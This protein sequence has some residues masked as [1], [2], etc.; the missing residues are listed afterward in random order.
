MNHYSIFQTSHYLNDN[1]RKMKE[2]GSE[3]W[4]RVDNVDQ[5]FQDTIQKNDRLVRFLREKAQIDHDYSKQLKKLA[6]KYEKGSNDSNFST[7]RAF[8]NGLLMKTISSI[9][10]KIRSDFILSFL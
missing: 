3:L 7:E 2:W 1:K 9:Y 10:I 8:R 6:S 5:R 4:D